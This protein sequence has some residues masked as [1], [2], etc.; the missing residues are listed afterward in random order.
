MIGFVPFDPHGD[1]EFDGR[2]TLGGADAFKFTATAANWPSSNGQQT[3]VT[4]TLF[5]QFAH[6]FDKIQQGAFVA[7][8]GEYK[9]YKKP[10]TGK[11]FHN[12]TG[13]RLFV[14]GELI[15]PVESE[16]TVANAVASSDDD[17]PF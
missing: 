11:M 2:V 1:N 5:E 10:E 15:E 17:L 12:L 9:P 16:R 4:I 8:D 14:N 13:Y 7:V 3:N 6:A